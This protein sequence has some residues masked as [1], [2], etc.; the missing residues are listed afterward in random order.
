MNT[1]DSHRKKAGPGT[2]SG[3]R[4]FNLQVGVKNL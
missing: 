4:V 1:I 2:R 3:Y